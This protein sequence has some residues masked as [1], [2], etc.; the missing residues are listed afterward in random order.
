MRNIIIFLF[1][2]CSFIACHQTSQKEKQLLSSA[3][4]IISVHPDR[5]LHLLSNIDNYRH[6]ASPD[7]ALYALLMTQA[8]DKCDSVVASDTLIRI[9]TDYFGNNDPVRA[10][11]AWF[12]RARCENNQGNVEGQVTSLLKAESYALQSQN[13]KLK[14]FVYGEKAQ[15]YQQQN[16]LDSALNCNKKAYFHLKKTGDKSNS[17]ICLINTGYSLYQIGKYN[18]ALRYYARAIDENPHMEPLLRSSLCGQQSL[19]YYYLQDYQNALRFARLSLTTSDMYDYAKTINIAIIFEKMNNVDS[20]TF[21]LQKC[22]S[23]HEMAPEYYKAWLDICAKQNNYRAVSYYAERLIASKDSLFQH[24][25]SESFAGLEKKFRYETIGSQNKSLIIENQHNKIIILFLLF[26]ISLGGITFSMFRNKRNTQL[27]VQQRRLIKNEKA[28]LKAAEEKALM[29][30]KQISTQ[31]KALQT[32]NKLKLTLSDLSDGKKNNKHTSLQQEQAAIDQIVQ[33]VI[34][35][36]N[37]LYN[38]ISIRLKNAYPD[39][40]ENEIQICCFLLAGFDNVTIYTTL[41]LQPA[42]Y[43]VKRTNL[44]KKLGLQHEVNLTDF[45]SNF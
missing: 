2:V 6:L 43:N 5:A 19:A 29:L 18:E 10:G 40:L 13:D 45:L 9:A 17:T 12:Y 24:S 36:V 11:Y 8:L 20:A 38:N 28:L 33:H 42:S 27:L 41:T 4:S 31:Q 7:R 37:Q 23:P 14:G 32:L 34:E 35:I 3:D 21:Y 25:L 1:L 22:S 15:L 26:G 39:L 30:Q 16:Q 44:R